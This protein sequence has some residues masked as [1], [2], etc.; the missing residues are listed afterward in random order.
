MHSCNA[1][2]YTTQGGVRVNL[3]HPNGTILYALLGMDNWH[4]DDD[5]TYVPPCT[6]Q[7]AACSLHPALC[8]L[9]AVLPQTVA[10]RA[11]GIVFSN[12]V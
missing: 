11:H 6:L 3:L 7:P 10:A 12:R 5:S 9:S 1:P 8:S 2:L 4:N